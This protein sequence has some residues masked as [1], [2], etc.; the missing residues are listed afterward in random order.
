MYFSRLL[1][2]KITK[3]SQY[4]KVLLIVGARQVGK[5]TILKHLHPNFKPYVF[6]P[7]TDLWNARQDPALFLQNLTPPVVLDEIQYS[8]QILPGLKRLVDTCDQKGMFYLTGSQN[9][10]MLKQAS[11]SLAGRMSIIEMSGITVFER[12]NQQPW[13]LQLLTHP[14][15]LHH[16]FSG[17]VKSPHS[18]YELILQGTLP[19][20]VQ[21]PFD[22]MHNYHESYIKTYLERDIRILEN[23]RDLSD[24]ERFL[25]LMGALTAQEINYQHLGREIGISPLTARRW[26]DALMH[27]YQWLSLPGYYNNTIKRISQKPKGHFADTGIACHL[28]GIS[29]AETL[30]RHPMLGNLFESYCVNMIHAMNQSLDNPAKL[31][32]FRTHNGAEV[33]LVLEWDGALFP[34]EIKCRSNI[35]RNDARGILALMETFPNHAVKLGL[36]LHAGTECYYVH[37]NILAMP[38]NGVLKI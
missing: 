32:H 22:A 30:S 26:L 7:I 17:C 36:I 4:F 16:Q 29:S 19:E 8:P 14:E 31:Y 5:S 6:D 38:W 2:G 15:K 18:L 34:I 3:L 28:V 20:A 24:F 12:Y 25:T 1:E 35:T 9:F 13:L 10:S 11:E 33:D 23:V 21:L 27:G 37:D